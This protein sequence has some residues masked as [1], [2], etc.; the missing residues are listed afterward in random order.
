MS[1]FIYGD[2]AF[3]QNIGKQLTVTKGDKVLCHM[4]YGRKLETKDYVKLAKNLVCTGRL[5]IGRLKK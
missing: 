1:E 2:Y 3:T 5:E 4:Y